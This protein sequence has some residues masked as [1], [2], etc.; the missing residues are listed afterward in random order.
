MSQRKQNLFD[1]EQAR[2]EYEDALTR[3]RG[4]IDS[5]ANALNANDSA[6]A[7]GYIFAAAEM[8]GLAL[9]HL[10][11]IDKI[12]HQEYGRYRGLRDR[13]DTLSADLRG[14]LFDP[15]AELRFNPS[16]SIQGAKS[17]LTGMRR[18]R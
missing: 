2:R 6:T 12:G 11:Y 15:G 7:S 13:L 5:A 8:L 9:G 4:Y 14:R 10:Q 17:R 18:R 16:P 3:A 1:P